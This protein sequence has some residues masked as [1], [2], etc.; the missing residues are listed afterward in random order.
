MLLKRY[1][2]NHRVIMK[3]GAHRKVPRL[4]PF[5]LSADLSALSAEKEWAQDFGKVRLLFCFSRDG[6]IDWT[7]AEL[8]Y[9]H[10]LQFDC[11]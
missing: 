1:A 9:R 10:I 11:G 3:S 8:I 6:D 5:F 7:L 4:V 2:L